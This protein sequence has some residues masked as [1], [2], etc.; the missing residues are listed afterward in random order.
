MK[1]IKDYNPNQGYFISFYPERFFKPNSLEM[2]IHE[3]IEKSTDLQPFKEKMK[4]N[5]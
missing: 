2:A 3:I 4:N 5:N 1:Q